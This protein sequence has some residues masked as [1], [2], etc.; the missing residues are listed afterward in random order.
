METSGGGWTVIQRRTND[1]VD[2]YQGWAEYIHG[3]GDADDDHWLGLS[4][5]HRLANSSMPLQLRVDLE[6]YAF[7]YRFAMYNSF[8]IG[9]PSTDYTLHV[10]G[11]SGTA[12]NAMAHNNGR[13][14]STKDN[15]NDAHG[16]LHCATYQHSG[17]WHGS[18]TNANLNGLF[19]NRR[20]ATPFAN[21][22][23]NLDGTNALEYSS[24]MIRANSD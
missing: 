1:S 23:N 8:Y 18:C 19:Y 3:F 15:D 4:K 10:S 22:W 9:G 21:Y 14:F 5:I 11:Y 12:G 20:T 2:F 6:S 17:W 16:S 13:K 7:G 24:M